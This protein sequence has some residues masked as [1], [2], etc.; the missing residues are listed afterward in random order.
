M[1]ITLLPIEKIRPNPDNPNPHSQENVA[2]LAANIKE[3]GL[4]NPITVRPLHDVNGDT[5]KFEVV[6]GAGRLR[7]YEKLW[8]DARSN[9]ATQHWTDIPAIIIYDQSDYGVWGRN[10]SENKLRSFNWQAECVCFARMRA[11]G[12]EWKQIAKVFGLKQ[13]TDVLGRIAVGSIPG[14]E[15]VMLQHNVS[16]DDAIRFL[17]PLRIETS[18]NPDNG[19]ERV[20]DYSEV[21]ACIDKLVSGELSK[22]DLPTHSAERRVAIK[23]A[24]QAARLK[25]IAAQELINW[26]KKLNE[27]NAEVRQ[28]KEQLQA[29]T[30][31]LQEQATKQAEKL[32]AEYEEKVKAATAEIS[33]IRNQIE[34]AGDEKAELQREIQ[35]LMEDRNLYEGQVTNLENQIVNLREQVELEVAEKIRAEMTEQLRVE[36]Q[37]EKNAEQEEEL[38]DAYDTIAREREEL[39]HIKQQLA[40]QKDDLKRKQTELEEEKKRIDA[41]RE[42]SAQLQDINGWIKVF[43]RFGDE[44]IHMIGVANAK[45]YW[46]IME[47]PEF[48]RIYSVLSGIAD[49]LR[50]VENSF[51]SRGIIGGGNERG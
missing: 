19:N 29:E 3:F 26:N 9:K 16:M 7:A 40:K 41:Q 21:T 6:A 45:Q 38:N 12:K 22:E 42:K 5:G 37:A 39:D 44:F 13:Q 24:Q 31:R 14:I 11:E 33:K 15:N 35:E 20:Y 47:K 32:K 43:N 49:Q 27:K 28:A 30:K 2:T 10:L 25:E 17:L 51:Q 34:N 46:D 36:I 18:R 50:Q 23:E 4:I 48:K 8:S 1:K